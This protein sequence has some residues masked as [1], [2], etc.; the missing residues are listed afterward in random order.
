MASERIVSPPR[1][2]FLR[3]YHMMEAKWAL[4]AIKNQRLKVSRF[5]NLNDPFRP[6]KRQKSR[7]RSTGPFE[8]R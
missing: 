2:T 4:V 5:E 8:F 1:E 7:H 6:P 3:V